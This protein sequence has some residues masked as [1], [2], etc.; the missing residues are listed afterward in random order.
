MPTPSRSTERHLTCPGTSA[1]ISANFHDGRRVN[2]VD[3]CKGLGIFYVVVGHVLRGLRQGAIVSESPVYQLIDSWLYSFHMPLF[4]FLAGLFVQPSSRRSVAEFTL[5][6][7]AVLIYPYF[8]WS[9]VQGLAESSHYANHPIPLTEL[10][11]IGW[12]PIAQY[13]FLYTLF[14]IFMIYFLL[15]KTFGSEIPFY[16]LSIV[17]F[18]LGQLMPELITWNVMHS[19]GSFAIYFGAGAVLARGPIL[20]QFN[21]FRSGWLSAICIGAYGLIAVALVVHPEHEFVLMPARAAAG[22]MA[23]IGLAILLAR[24]RKLS[25]IELW[26]MLS[27]EIYVAHSLAAAPVRV[28]LHNIFGFE[29][30][31]LYVAVGV[32]AGLYGPIFLAYVCDRLGFPFAFRTNRLRQCTFENS[33][34]T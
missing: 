3:Y 2:W 24:L 6:K 32:V 16:C 26:G 28:A 10:L 27:L 34:R 31:W 25:L 20:I 19:V 21:E 7:A 13:W 18:L 14:I 11:K 30:A 33:S 5:N 17:W 4:F 12:S 1:N 9:I 29:G 8:L 22:T 15:F 23:T